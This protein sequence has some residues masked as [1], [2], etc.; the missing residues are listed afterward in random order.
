MANPRTPVG[1]D[2]PNSG[3]F[4]QASPSRFYPHAVS[5]PPVVDPI[6]SSSY[7]PRGDKSRRGPPELRGRYATVNNLNGIT[8]KHATWTDF[9][10]DRPTIL[11]PIR[12]TVSTLAPS[13]TAACGSYYPVYYRPDYIGPSNPNQATD[14]GSD[15]GFASQVSTG[16]GVVFLAQPG[17]WWLF[18]GVAATDSTT[19]LVV[20]ASEPGTVSRY[21]SESGC[22][23]VAQQFTLAVSTPAV[24]IIASNRNRTGLA[25]YNTSSGGGPVH[26]GF[27]IEAVAGTGFVLYQPAAAQNP[28]SLILTGS[29][30]WK[31][32]VRG[33]REAAVDGQVSVL[34]WE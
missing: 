23:R 18:C 24:T 25:I 20:D 6:L 5:A 2:V 34:E 28:S 13:T 4:D 31:G 21:L 9:Y 26:L 3:G 22:H 1:I 7:D 10:V 30:L 16:A 14:A 17:R 29:T 32:A 19:F 12:S 8:L 27:G 33:I 15:A 11:W